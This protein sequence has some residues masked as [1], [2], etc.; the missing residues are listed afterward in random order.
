MKKSQTGISLS[1]W[2]IRIV[3]LAAI[4]FFAGKLTIPLAS[5]PA[6]ASPM[7]PAAGLALGGVLAFG[8]SVW[9]GVFLG[10]LLLHILHFYNAAEA[11]PA[12]RML[13]QSVGIASGASL[14]ALA[15]AF[16]IRK[17]V[18]FPVSLNRMY[19]VV[20][21]MLL[22]GPAA[23]VIGA[24]VCV[25][26]LLLTGAIHPKSWLPFW[27]TWWLGNTLGVLVLIPLASAFSME[28]AKTRRRNQLFVV[29][30]VLIAFAL[31]VAVFLNVRK[32]EWKRA[33]LVF[34]R[35]SRDI[36]DSLFAN[37][38][39]Y[40]EVMYSIGE[41][42][43]V[44]ASVDRNAFHLLTEGLLSRHPGI[45]A[46]EWIP[47]I[48]G[49]QRSFYE[50]AARGD[51]FLQFGISALDS[52]KKLVAAPS[53]DE[54]FPVYYVEPYIGNEK[55]LGYDLSTNPARL[56]ALDKARDLGK[57][58]ATSRLVLVQEKGTQSGVLIFLPVY[59]HGSVPG[60]TESRL[61]DLRGFIL[62]VFRIGDM[63]AAAVKPFDRRNIAIDLLDRTAPSGEQ[64]LFTSRAQPSGAAAV[65][66]GGKGDGFESL[67]RLQTFEIGE[68]QWSIVCSPTDSYRADLHLWEAWAVLTGGLFFCSMLGAFLLVVVGQSV[69]TERIVIERTAELSQVNAE[70]S[71]V[72][73]D[74]EREIAIH[75]E[76]ESALKTSEEKF[77]TFV[78]WTGDWEYW[79]TPDGR[80]VYMTPSCERITGYS[81]QAFIEDPGLIKA[82]L[83]G[84]DYSKWEGHPC[85][86]FESEAAESEIEIRIVAKN[87]DT[88]WVSHTC[89]PVFQEGG[90]YLGRRV[91]NRDITERKRVEDALHMATKRANAMAQ[92]AQ[93]A[94][95]AKSDFLANMSHELRTP[96]N[97]IIGFTELVLDKQCGGLTP[98]QEEYLGD[99]A[100]SARDLFL[101]INDVLDLT[102][103][104]AGK[105]ELELSE[106]LLPELLSRSFTILKEK[107]LKHNIQLSYEVKDIPASIIA[108][109][110][111]LKQ[112]IYNLLANA[113]KF[114][115]DGGRVH[116]EAEKAGD[117]VQVSI[118]DTGIGIKE[119]DLQRIFDPFEQ[120]ESSLSR[121]FQGTGLGLSLTRS[122]VELHGGK[123]WAESEGEGKGAGFFF[124]MPMTPPNMNVEKDE[125][126]R[127]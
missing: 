109:E 39:S 15:G 44:G 46:L 94:N 21:I 67:A 12:S 65:A 55:A 11:L 88:R 97:V 105:L 20:K 117:F 14:Q 64:V 50:D 75:K 98:Q 48:P 60:D 8:Y 38:N 91:S 116:M 57:A 101:L 3:G 83:P 125:W 33:Q 6:Y 51:G 120:A 87:G 5:L 71:R 16:L 112:V 95:V 7:W 79:I 26:V 68:R 62:G 54:Y 126:K 31:T 28:M 90:A 73:E 25:A 99:V 19:D 104:E 80:F 41:F 37:L 1:A 86:H 30:P 121:R 18:R 118:E 58:V 43:R 42:Y 115:P 34:E 72:N 13:L 96:L 23:C 9:P 2:A 45:Q 119:Q 53:K 32:E 110:R 52:Q 29:I 10:S 24:A 77:R 84:D 111:K 36:T 127:K 114:T 63:V 92:R 59:A 27:G 74:L 124:L 85:N 56:D 40:M 107:A 35:Q 108:D 81:P 100:H 102:R 123:I 61:L 17:A 66:G 78:D 93:A 82:I 47:R 113:V 76:V 22:G 49:G 69:T 103:I 89:R 4:Y 70:L 106:V 122:M